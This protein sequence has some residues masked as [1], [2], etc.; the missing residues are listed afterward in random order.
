MKK[1]IEFNP[2]FKGNVTIRT[3]TKKRYEVIVEQFGIVSKVEQLNG[4]FGS[5]NETMDYIKKT[6]ENFPQVRVSVM[7]SEQGEEDE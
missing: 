1:A 3:G 4:C 2:E 5:V 6:L 7:V